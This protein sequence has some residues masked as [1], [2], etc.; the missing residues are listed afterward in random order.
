[1]V[2]RERLWVYPEGAMSAGR[3]STGY[4]AFDCCAALRISFMVSRMNA[5]GSEGWREVTSG[6]LSFQAIY[7]MNRVCRSPWTP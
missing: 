3:Y 6:R 2:A 7:C 5:G 1:L 4:A